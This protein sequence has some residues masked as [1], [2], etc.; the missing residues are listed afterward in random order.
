MKPDIFSWSEYGYCRPINHKNLDYEIETWLY[1]APRVVYRWTINHKNLDYEIETAE[2][3]PHCAKILSTINHKNLDYE[4]ETPY[5]TP[6]PNSF[7]AD[8]P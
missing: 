8:Q 3:Q 4:I 5:Y 2:Y 7:T 1:Y 6:Y